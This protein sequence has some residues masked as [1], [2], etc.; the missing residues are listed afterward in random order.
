MKCKQQRHGK[1]FC[2]WQQKKG[3]TILL[4]PT[5]TKMLQHKDFHRAIVTRF[6]GKASEANVQKA[7][8]SRSLSLCL[9]ANIEQHP[10]ASRKY[11][12]LEFG[13]DT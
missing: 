6:K 11:S 7:Q 13:I 9:M 2:L 3:K 12:D 8:S 10:K 5:S 4:R 1:T